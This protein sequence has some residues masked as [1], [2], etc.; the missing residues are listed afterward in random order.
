MFEYWWLIGCG[1]VELGWKGVTYLFNG[2]QLVGQ[3]AC[4]IQLYFRCWSVL[5]Y[6]YYT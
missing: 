2:S 3:A 6:I 5:V 1:I 4:L